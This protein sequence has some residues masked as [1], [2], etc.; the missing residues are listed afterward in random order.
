MA[1]QSILHR[2]ANAKDKVK[3]AASDTSKGAKLRGEA[4]G[5]AEGKAQELKGEAKGSAA[6]AKGT[7][8]EKIGEAK[9]AVKGKV[10]EL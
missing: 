6:E 5:T 8:K 2:I 10:N 7:V 9:G 4:Q 3:E 1:N